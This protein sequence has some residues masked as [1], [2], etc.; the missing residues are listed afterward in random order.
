M[1]AHPAIATAFLALAPLE[2]VLLLRL[3]SGSHAYGLAHAESDEDER[4]VFFVPDRH[5]GALSAVPDQVS[6]AKHDHVYYSL[7]RLF[8]LLL[9]ANPGAVE[10]IAAPLDTHIACDPR[11]AALWDAADLFI[12]QALVRAHVGYAQGQI[13]KAR[14]QN[15]W[16]NHPQPD[17]RPS[18]LG[19]CHWIPNPANG[20]NQAV[21]GLPGR[22]LPMARLP[23]ALAHC[24]VARVD[25]AGHCYRLYHLGPDARGVFR[26]GE[27]EEGLP[28]CESIAK[29]VEESG[30][31]GLMVYNDAGYQ[32]AKLDHQNYWQ[33]RRERNESRWRQ[34]ARGELD[35]DAKN[36]MHCVRLL[37]SAEHM[38]DHGTA[39]VR[40]DSANRAELLAIRNGE[41]G[42]DAL[43]ASTQAQTLRVQQKL[44]STKLPPDIDHAR[45]RRLYDALRASLGAA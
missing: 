15:K 27:G 26:G 9:D 25:H 40:V 44:V 19:F 18:A 5:Y 21:A 8:T 7:R 39:L 20:L 3:R 16:I 24:H 41:H 14:G 45:V 6:D 1:Q 17:A 32:R 38:L 12:T 33:W 29:S 28:V 36:M 30:F 4:G 2:P 13:K 43:V 11:L 35:F 37:K 31:L 22:T 34:Q 10:M 42:F 23:V